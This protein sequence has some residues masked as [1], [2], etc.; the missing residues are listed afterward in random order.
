[1]ATSDFLLKM[2][3]IWSS[4]STKNKIINPGFILVAEERNFAPKKK[5]TARIRI[6]YWRARIEARA[7]EMEGA[8]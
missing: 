8:D 2:W 3:R 7:E 1:M 4:F 5:N 6:G